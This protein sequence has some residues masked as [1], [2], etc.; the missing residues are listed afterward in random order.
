[1]PS[2]EFNYTGAEPARYSK[3][4]QVKRGDATFRGSAAAEATTLARLSAPVL[5][6]VFLTK[7]AKPGGAKHE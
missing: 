7:S 1:M 6:S 5:T 3:I 2:Q 4:N